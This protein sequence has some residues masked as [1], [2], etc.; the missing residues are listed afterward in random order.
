MNDKRIQLVTGTGRKGPVFERTSVDERFNSLLASDMA[1][2]K[3]IMSL[4][5]ALM[6]AGHGSTWADFKDTPYGKEVVEKMDTTERGKAMA[7]WAFVEEFDKALEEA[8]PRFM[9]AFRML[10]EIQ[11]E[12]NSYGVL[13]VSFTHD[14][15]RINEDLFTRLEEFVARNWRSITG[16]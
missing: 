16:T 3:W 5:D 7:L 1:A 12:K 2:T 8:A 15:A 10:L 4:R 13:N 14:K 6:I 9:A 11:K